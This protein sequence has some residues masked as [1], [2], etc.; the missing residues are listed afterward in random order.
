MNSTKNPL[1]PPS[2]MLLSGSVRRVA[3]YFSLFLP[4]LQ[5]SLKV[6]N[7][8]TTRKNARHRDQMRRKITRSPPWEERETTQTRDDAEQ[9][10]TTRS[11]SGSSSALLLA[12][13]AEAAATASMHEKKVVEQE[14]QQ[15]QQG[16][17]RTTSSRATLTTNKGT[18]AKTIK[19]RPG[20]TLSSYKTIPRFT[21]AASGTGCR[22]N[23]MR[24][25]SRTQH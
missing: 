20:D 21:M 19:L 4:T 13:Q 15:H 5:L 1:L 17:Q 2:V 25:P 3:L 7:S 8:E 6:V 10:R 24:F 12:E 9:T 14:E 22:T 16:R 18:D 23:C 11:G